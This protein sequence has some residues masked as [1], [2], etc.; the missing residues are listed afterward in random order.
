[1]YL[2]A[3]EEHKE[4]LRIMLQTLRQEQLYGKLSKYEFFLD[5][6]VFL[7]HVISKESI[8]VDPKVETVQDWSVP[9]SVSDVRSFLGLVGY[10][11][12]FV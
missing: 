11:R 10:Y 6:V 8:I 7:G 3:Q 4:H 2:R 12:R 1:M 5:S 9:K